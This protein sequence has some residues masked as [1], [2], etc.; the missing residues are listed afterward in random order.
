MINL[1]S[2]TEYEE[3]TAASRWREA[4]FGMFVHFGL[5]SVLGR[6]EWAMASENWSVED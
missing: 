1:V 6:H 2:K 4:R 3:Q 5:Y